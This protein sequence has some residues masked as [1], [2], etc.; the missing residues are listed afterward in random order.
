MYS[1]VGCSDCAHLWIVEGRPE[2]TECRRCG[3]RHDFRSRRRL[4]ETEDPDQ[5]RELRSRLLAE[6]ANAGEGPA[7][8]FDVLEEEVADGVIRALEPIE[9][10]PDESKPT[11]KRGIVL[12]AIEERAEPTRS[13]I[14]E[15]GRDRGLASEEVD[16]VLEKLHRAGTVTR[17]GDTYRR[18]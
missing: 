4:A 7:D 3:A 12:E 8:S 2:T 18:V 1:V 9:S 6:R 13:A 11:D 15:H 10:V 16:S 14:R 5:A 17:E